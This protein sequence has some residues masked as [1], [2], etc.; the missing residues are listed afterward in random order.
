M[1]AALPLNAENLAPFHTLYGADVKNLIAAGRCISADRASYASI[2][3][4][5][6]VMAIG[7]AAGIAA[8]LCDKTTAAKDVS[9]PALHEK[10]HAAGAICFAADAQ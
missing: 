2:R 4:Q 5:A 7:E 8:A 10:L 1:A 9:I 3:V 6:T